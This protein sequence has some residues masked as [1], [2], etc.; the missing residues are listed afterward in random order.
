MQTPVKVPV[1]NPVSNTVRLHALGALSTQ[2]VQIT[3]AAGGA[4]AEAL[5]AAS[6]PG[7]GRPPRPKPQSP[8][9]YP[10]SN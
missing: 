4:T 1:P 8:N 7:S 5:I 10:F 9:R 3:I 6:K 2:L